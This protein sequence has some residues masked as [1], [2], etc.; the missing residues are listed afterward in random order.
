MRRR[1][2][3]SRLSRSSKSR[4]GGRRSK[5]RRIRTWWRSRGKWRFRG[6]KRPRPETRCAGSSRRSSN[7]R[8]RGYCSSKQG[9]WK[10]R[11]WRWN[12]GTRKGERCRRGCRLRG[13]E[14]PLRR[15]SRRSRRLSK[16]RVRLNR[17]C[18]CKDR[19]SKRENNLSRKRG[20]SLKSQEKGSGLKCN[21]D[22]QWR[23]RRWKRS[24]NNHSQTL[25]L[26]S[27]SF[28]MHN[29]SLNRGRFNL[30]EKEKDLLKLNAN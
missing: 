19:I 13:R 17:R 8:P 3:V 16:R 27:K 25:K 18:L 7:S 5:T 30:L 9:R 20:N 28:S 26:A 21:N 29:K 4:R 24:C 11:S 15:G 22:L 23:L 10:G 1:G 2:C 6:R 12:E 14:L